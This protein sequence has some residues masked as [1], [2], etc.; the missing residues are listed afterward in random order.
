VTCGPVATTYRVLDRSASWQLDLEPGSG[1]QLAEVIE[2]AALDAAAIDVSAL[3]SVMP[4]PW[5]ARGCGAC[6]WYVLCPPNRVLRYFCSEWVAITGDE[7]TLSLIEPVAIAASHAR[8]AILDVGRGEVLIATPGGERV[9]ASMPTTARGPIA[10]SRDALFIADGDRL[11]RVALMTLERATLPTAPGPIERVLAA[12]DSA[13]IA[14]RDGAAHHLYRLEA[15]AWSAATLEELRAVA[16]ESGVV[17]ASDDRACL[18][19]SRGKAEPRTLCIDRCAKPVDP[20]PGSPGQARARAGSLVTP[21]PIDSGIPRCVWHRVRVELELPESTGL[22]IKLATIEDLAQP[23]APDDWQIVPDVSAVTSEGAGLR[24]CDFLIEQPPGRYLQLQLDLRGDGFATPR[25]HRMRIDFPRS[26][27]ALRLPGVYREDPVAADFLD[28]FVAAFDASIEDLDRV[29]TRFPALIDPEST[30]AEALTWLGSFLDIA[31]DPAWSEATRRAILSAAPELYRRRGTPWALA[32]AI[33]LA[34]GVAPAILELSGTSPYART[35][36]F[37]L[38]GSRL[39]GRAAARVR[40][41]ASVLGAAPLH[42][43]GDPD[44]DHVSAFGFRI[45]VQVPALASPDARE[46]LRRLVDAQTPAHVVAQVRVGGEHALLGVASAVGI[47]T[48]L[49][50]LPMPRLGQNTRLR[51]M[52]A[53]A[54]SGARGL[55][56]FRVGVAPAIGIQTVL[57]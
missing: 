48:R 45:M 2:L 7:R 26:T 27:S 35:G 39:F 30:P 18:A 8:I 42:S 54:R 49:G 37:K 36:A 3:S 10:L 4:P 50:G 6:E 56:G 32:R 17:A 44:R 29:I 15:G 28:R 22:T 43:Y 47:D 25:I 23:I 21:L 33:E 5:L 14:L 20:P 57:S 55:A 41:G 9:I 16:R 46:R 24:M 11:E 53:L 40:L 19:L 38:G 13:W 52:T 51:R 1:V 31:L 34:V 12:G